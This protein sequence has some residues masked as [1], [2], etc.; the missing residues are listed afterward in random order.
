MQSYLQ[1]WLVESQNFIS[2]EATWLNV[3][4]IAPEALPV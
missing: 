1:M 4:E 3:Q 2:T